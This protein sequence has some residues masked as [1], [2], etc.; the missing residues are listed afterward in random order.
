MKIVILDDHSVRQDDL[1][2]HQLE[3][4]PNVELT[5]YER[6]PANLT[7]ERSREAEGV[8]TNKVVFDKAIIEQ[9]P[10][11]RYIGVLATGYNVV[12]LEAAHKHGITV[13]YIP[14]YSTPSVAQLVFALLLHVTNSVAHY[15]E[16]NSKGRWTQ[17]PDFMW[18]DTKITELEGKTMVIRGMGNIGMRVAKIA[19]AMGIRVVAVSN[20]T[21]L[22]SD[23][24]RAT[25]SEAL[26]QADILSLNCPLT[27]ETREIIND[28]TLALMQPSAIIINTGRGPL[29]NEQ[30]V[31]M[32]LYENRIQ[33]YCADVLSVEPARKDCPL[34]TAPRCYLTP[35]IA[36]ASSESRQRLIDVAVEN[37]VAF[38]NGNP[39]N[40]VS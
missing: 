33:A 17:S 1:D 15:A 7:V 34:L 38:I 39:K 8:F 20:R 16:E 18:M 24:E 31:A 2:W 9:L 37:L 40:V 25:W 27:D 6:T 26:K 13:T 29:V 30:A 3:Q 23:I 12:D 19:I 35:H 11:L 36:W 5:T 10:K 32:A 21:D 14:A 28:E 22:P 4:L